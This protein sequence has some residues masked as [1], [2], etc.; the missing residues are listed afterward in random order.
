MAKNKLAKFADM[1]TY[2]NVFQYTFDTLKEEGFPFKGKWHTYFGNTNPVVLELG[3]GKGEYTVGLARKFPEKNFIGIDIKGARMWTGASQA[4]EEGLTNAAFLRTRIELINH[5]FA[6]D[7]VSEIWITFPD[8]QM[9][10]TNK[11]LTATRFMEQYSRMLKEGGIIHL[12]TDSNFLYRYT[13]AMIAENRIETFFD[14]EDLYNS[15]LNGDILEIRTFYEQQWLSRGLNIK[16]IR[17]LCPKNHNWTE[18]NVEIEKDEYRSFG[19]D[20]RI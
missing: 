16:Y 2:E 3:C 7:E 12:K 20:A 14:T 9:K 8:P 1:A 4:L 17:F 11:R 15:G 6:Q 19:R 13:K 18:P 10:K 5:F